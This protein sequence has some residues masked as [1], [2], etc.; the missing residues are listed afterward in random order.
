MQENATNDIRS[1]ILQRTYAQC[2]KL[3]GPGMDSTEPPTQ[4]N[5]E[6]PGVAYTA[7][8]DVSYPLSIQEQTA[9]MHAR[10]L[11]HV[12]MGSTEVLNLDENGL[13]PALFIENAAD[14]FSVQ[15]EGALQG[16]V[17]EFMPLTLRLVLRQPPAATYEQ[18]TVV[19]AMHYRTAFDYLLDTQEF[20]SIAAVQPG[21]SRQSRVFDAG[22]TNVE[23][24]EGEYSPYEVIDFRFEVQ[25][26]RPK[27]R[28]IR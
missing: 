10:T 12:Q 4:W 2:R 24:L 9:L 7:M 16:T 15:G 11:Q 14:G 17:R 5:R 27:E 21:D 8:S 20:R 25:F 28:R 13:L 6:F 18:S 3:L 23:N 1:K 26:D 19:Q 22:I